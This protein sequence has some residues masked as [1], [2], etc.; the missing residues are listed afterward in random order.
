M[1]KP[2][3]TMFFNPDLDEQNSELED[4]FRLYLTFKP[5]FIKQYF[6]SYE[7]RQKRKYPESC[8]LVHTSKTDKPNT[9]L[10]YSS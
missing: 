5:I 9:I 4:L 3:E 7:Q 8:F 6:F 1:Y 2:E 10:S